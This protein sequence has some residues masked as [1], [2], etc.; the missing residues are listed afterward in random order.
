MVADCDERNLKGTAGQ[1][2]T[3]SAQTLAEAY[4]A[5]DVL[6]TSHQSGVKLSRDPRDMNPFD[7]S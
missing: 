4:R 7:R 1:P 3:G 6:S 5:D 2:R